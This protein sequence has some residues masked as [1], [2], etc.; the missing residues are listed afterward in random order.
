LL[1]VFR[2]TECRQG[3]FRREEAAPYVFGRHSTFTNLQGRA[4]FERGTSI[5]TWR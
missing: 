3:V 1:T 2:Q 5:E 4:P